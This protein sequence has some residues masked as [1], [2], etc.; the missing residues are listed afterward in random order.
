MHVT[1]DLLLVVV[2]RRPSPSLPVLRMVRVGLNRSA[3]A[4]P[5]SGG[6]TGSC[7]DKYQQK[8]GGNN[9]LS[10]RDY[11]TS[12]ST[13][14]KPADATDLDLFGQEGQSKTLVHMD[15]QRQHPSLT[16]R[17]LTTN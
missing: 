14:S 6:E 5:E 11:V 9:S 13:E 12:T 17:Q 4:N 3:G 10:T 15:E 2:V 1:L 8:H 16:I 7:W